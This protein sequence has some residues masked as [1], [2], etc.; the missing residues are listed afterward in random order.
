[1]AEIYLRV[2]MSMWI[3]MLMTRSRYL[4]SASMTFEVWSQPVDEQ[5]AAAGAD[6]ATGAAIDTVAAAAAAVD[7]DPL[8]TPRDVRLERRVREL[9]SKNDDLERE[10]AAEREAAAAAAAALQAAVR[11]AF[12][13][14]T[15]SVLTEIS[16][17]P[18]LFL[19]RN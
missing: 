9:E 3:L 15:R 12:P 13:L 18:R 16:P 1:L 17:M 8:Q 10:L 7:G 4:Q 11:R 5:A 14:I 19:S 2:E 6:A